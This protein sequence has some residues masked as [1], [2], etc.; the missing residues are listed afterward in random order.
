MLLTELK[1]QLTEVKRHLEDKIVADDASYQAEEVLKII[2]QFLLEDQ[3]ED[4]AIKEH[5]TRLSRH[6]ENLNTQTKEKLDLLD[7]VP[8]ISK[9]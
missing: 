9:F 4:I 5:L 2:D 7:F 3:D 6:L 1:N 8:L